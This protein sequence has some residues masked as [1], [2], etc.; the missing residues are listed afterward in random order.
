[1]KQRP[2]QQQI[3]LLVCT[4]DRGKKEDCCARFGSEKVLDRLKK[5]IKER[6]LQDVV[7]VVPTGCLDKCSKGPNVLIFP[8]NIWACKVDGDDVDKLLDEALA[9]IKGAK[10]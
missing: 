1:M 6:K 2:L 4:R 3:A 10:E 5:R 8:G 7:R 9:R